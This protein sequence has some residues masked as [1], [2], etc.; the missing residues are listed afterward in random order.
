MAA[1][2]HAERAHAAVAAAR[3]AAV[4]ALATRVH[5]AVLAMIAAR[6]PLDCATHEW[7]V[8]LGLDAVSICAEGRLPGA[9]L[10][11]SG[12]VQRLM[13]TAPALVR[14]GVADSLLHGEATALARTEAL[15]VVPLAAPALLAIACR[16][17]R[18]LIP[19][20]TSS[21]VF[22]G[23]ALAAALGRL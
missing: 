15:V 5:A 8:L 10:L 13:G 1:M 22:L 14:P 16:D 20:G 4:A 12:T 3:T 6:D 11:P 23:R 19:D 7:P 17:G 2:L 18:T 21:L 9:R